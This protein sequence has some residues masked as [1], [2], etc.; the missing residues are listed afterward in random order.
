MKLDVFSLTPDLTSAPTEALAAE[1]AGYDTWFCAETGHDV[2]LL[3][4]M[5]ANA[6]ST[7][8]IATGIAVAFARSP[9]SLAYQAN[10]IQELS[11]GRFTLGLGTQ[12]KPHIERRFSMP[13]SKPAARMKEY[14]QALHAIWAHFNDGAPLDF[15]G[16][17]Y[18]HDLTNPFFVPAPHDFGRPEIH[19]A[20]VGPLMSRTAAEV[21]DGIACHSFTTRAYF[22]AVTR[23]AIDEGLSRADRDRSSFQ[24]GVGSFVVTGRTAEEREATRQAVVSQLSFYGSTPAY[25][26]VL[27][28]HGW[29]E[30]QPRLQAMSREGRWD[31]MA[32]EI[33]DEM[34]EE[35]A[36]VVDD[37]DDVGA[38][39][40]ERW[41]DVVD[42]A[43]LYPTWT[44]DDRALASIRTAIDEVSS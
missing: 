2:M 20:A 9:M 39:Y 12:I 8:G 35:L 30:L 11:R 21:A 34:L 43:S 16:E 24:V 42:R 5:A 6:T 36:L 31:E 18:R 25:A 19:L 17:F 3:T 23:P 1:S 13:W 22:D 37:P 44:P 29:E 27:A 15:H 28:E 4:A 10:D 7:V 40:V 33:T 26:A 41:G 32:D 38:A 14:V